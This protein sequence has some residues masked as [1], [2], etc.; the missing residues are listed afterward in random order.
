MKKAII[1]LTSILFS[2]S[3]FSQLKPD[4]DTYEFIYQ[5]VFEV[6][7]TK[8]QLKENTNAWMVKTFKNTNAGI[9]L[10]SED[11]LI[12]KGRF[13]GVF[14]DG[15]GSKSKTEFNYIIEISFKEGRYRM[16]ISNFTIIPDDDAMTALAN[17]G[18]R[19]PTD[20]LSKYKVLQE[21]DI[22]RFVGMGK[23][24]MLKRLESTK[25]NVKDI[26]RQKKYF[27]V[28]EPQ[29][30]KVCTLLSKSLNGYLKKK[31]DW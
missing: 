17:W 12:A 31:D 25:K 30:K 28:I 3:V 15:L 29:I 10:N 27:N 8:E 24:M 11:N 16:T 20:D 9:K 5:E 4:D 14:R 2:A 1:I 13:E 26:E 6:K 23:K 22:N 21:S 7:L 18:M 19:Y